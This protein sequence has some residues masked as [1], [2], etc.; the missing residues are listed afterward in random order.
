[1]ANIPLKSMVTPSHADQCFFKD[2]NLKFLHHFFKVK[3]YKKKEK[4]M[5]LEKKGLWRFS[6]HMISEKTDFA[7]HFFIYSA[8]L[9]NISSECLS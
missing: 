7:C 6:V 4:K 3:N 8:I 5:K 1:M 9:A 2:I